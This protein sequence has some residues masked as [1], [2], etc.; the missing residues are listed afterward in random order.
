MWIKHYYSEEDLWSGPGINNTLINYHLFK[1]FSAD[2]P[3]I[4][5]PNDIDSDIL[6]NLK[7]IYNIIKEELLDFEKE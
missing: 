3:T 4:I 6:N 2:K 5:E 1:L 7:L